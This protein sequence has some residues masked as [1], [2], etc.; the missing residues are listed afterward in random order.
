MPWAQTPPENGH[1]DDRTS[2]R[3]ARL[4]LKGTRP[5][6]I[7]GGG[8]HNAKQAKYGG[9]EDYA[10]LDDETLGT[11][12]TQG[13]RRGRLGGESCMDSSLARRGSAEHIH[14]EITVDIDVAA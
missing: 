10:C 1:W 11:N 4:A 6:S 2:P 5:S 13:A 9:G 7:D 12:W 14:G 3:Q 8:L